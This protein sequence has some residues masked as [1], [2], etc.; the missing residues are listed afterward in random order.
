[1]EH[2]HRPGP[3]KQQNR[4]H[5][6]SR[7]TKG[8]STKTPGLSST[9]GAVSLG[10]KERR[11]RANQ[12][13]KNK[14]ELIVLEKR[15]HGLSG[16]PPHL[17]LLVPMAG[18]IQL[19]E[20]CRLLQGQEAATFYCAG[21]K[22][23]FT[24]SS[25]PYGQLYPL[26]DLAK[27]CDSL[28]FI[29]SVSEPISEWAEQVL[30][31]LMA[32]GLPTPCH[33]VRGLDTV[34]PKDRSQTRNAVSAVVHNLLP[35]DSK[36]FPLDSRSD[37]DC[38]LRALSQQKR[39][40]LAYRDNRSQLYGELSGYDV[41]MHSL[42]VRGYL[43]GKP[44]SPNQLLHVPG[45]GDFQISLIETS[46]DPC[47][48]GGNSR[49]GGME[50]E[51]ESVRLVPDPELQA[52]LDPEAQVDPM[53]GEQ[54]W[55]TG[56]ELKSILK[57]EKSYQSSWIPE[58]AGDGSGSEGESEGARGGGED[59]GSEDHLSLGSEAES[60][61]GMTDT[62]TMDTTD[63][64]RTCDPSAEREQLEKM[65]AQREEAMF[66]DEVDTPVDTPARVRFQKY[67]GLQSFRSSPWDRSENLPP[68]YGR[69]FKFQN[70]R[71]TQKRVL[72]RTAEGQEAA[73]GLYVTVHLRDF[74]ADLVPLLPPSLV[75][76]S[77]L[78][79]EQK[80]S[81]MHFAVKRASCEE[82]VQ[83]K[84]RLL[85]QVGCRRYSAS[86]IYSQH[87]PGDKHKFERFFRGG[88]T[89]VASVYAPITFPS[90]P[91]LLFTPPSQA[92]PPHLVATGT[93]LAAGP[94]RITCKRII[95]SGHPLR[96]HR[97]SAVVRYMFFGREDIDW[98][99][100]VQ[101]RTKQGRVGNIKE[102]L[103]THGHMKCT[104]DKQLK[105]Q[106]TV[107]MH[108]Y[109]RVYPKWSYSPLLLDTSV[110]EDRMEMEREK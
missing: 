80:M 54:T 46:P 49:G 36:L 7:L 105:A 39:R 18:D 101:L 32:Q 24:V 103:G 11:N 98:F 41:T 79:F 109:K 50:S 45:A 35:V 8:D 22:Q 30:S 21:V 87:C 34:P 6:K 13:R 25:A 53:E 4:P 16:S 33:V 9:R 84:D 65:R 42:S 108:L 83:S 62:W 29:F 75:L 99:R 52:S 93:V 63:Y 2:R 19:E 3:L 38:L 69:I 55:P 81:L 37:A 110:K 10:R 95:L 76:F 43:R 89:Y 31:V 20:V 28:L 90:C 67:R 59:S 60:D 85:L 66:P 86:P 106:D 47:P 74:P 88:G 61:S 26:L 71:A 23:R 91:V 17:L 77:L 96:I 5:K 51:G 15:A 82:V 100:P 64:D 72:G 107:L 94:D 78:Q 57:P 1:M 58:A 44:L 27:A 97:R 70:F 102:A 40:S 48:F 73:A 12:I 68:E 104:F 92:S 14:R 56:E